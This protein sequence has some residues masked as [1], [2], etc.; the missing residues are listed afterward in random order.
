[1]ILR[2]DLLF[3]HLADNRRRRRLGA[4]GSGKVIELTASSLRFG[5]HAWA[6]FQIAPPTCSLCARRNTSGRNPT[7]CT[8]PV[9]CHRQRKTGPVFFASDSIWLFTTLV[10]FRKF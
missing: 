6:S 1:M 9:I 5:D 10:I 4:E 8:L 7:P 2:R 3:N